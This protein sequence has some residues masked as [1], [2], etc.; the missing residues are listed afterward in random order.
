MKKKEKKSVQ[1]GGGREGITLLHKGQADS[2]CVSECQREGERARGRGAETDRE[3]EKRRA[4]SSSHHSEH[5][6]RD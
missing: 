2:F 4:D 6:E 1:T 3:S 5:C